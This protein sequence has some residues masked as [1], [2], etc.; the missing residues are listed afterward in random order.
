M[1]LLDASEAALR[2]KEA[3]DRVREALAILDESNAPPEI[4]GHLDLA[5]CRLDDVLHGKPPQICAGKLSGDVKRLLDTSL[6]E[7]RLLGFAGPSD[8]DIN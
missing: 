4:G 7:D 6:S 2:W 8:K 1:D 3:L 5:V